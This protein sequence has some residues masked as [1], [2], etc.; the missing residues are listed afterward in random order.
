[1]QVDRLK[2]DIENLYIS[3]PLER[4]TFI[5]VMNENPN[6]IHSLYLITNELKSMHYYLSLDDHPKWTLRAYVSVHHGY[7]GKA[8]QQISSIKSMSSKNKQRPEISITYKIIDK[9]NM[10][11]VFSFR[12]RSTNKREIYNLIERFYKK[13]EEL[14][15]VN[16]F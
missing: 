5:K 13:T 15:K 14:C 16:T 3:K 2:I 9:S 11:E 7:C 8:K 4:E 10:K 6:T 12:H 1:M